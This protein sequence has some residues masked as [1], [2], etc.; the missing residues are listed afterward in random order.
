MPSNDQILEGIDCPL[1]TPEEEVGAVMRAALDLVVACEGCH[2]ERGYVFMFMLRQQIQDRLRAGEH[3]ETIFG[4]PTMRRARNR[5]LILFGGTPH[6]VVLPLPEGD[7][8]EWVR[9]E[10]ERLWKEHGGEA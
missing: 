4:D 7:D 9:A 8:A 10:M 3:P 5:S 1:C 6:T 2:R